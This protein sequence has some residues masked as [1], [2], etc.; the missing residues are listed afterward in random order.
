MHLSTENKTTV[1]SRVYCGVVSRVGFTVGSTV[2]SAVDSAPV[3]S[4]V[5]MWSSSLVVS[6]WGSSVRLL[7]AWGP[8][9]ETILWGS[10]CASSLLLGR[11]LLWVFVRNS[12]LPQCQ[13]YQCLIAPTP[14]IPVCC[15]VPECSTGLRVSLGKMWSCGLHRRLECG[16]HDTLCINI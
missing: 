10:K 7:F 6:L 16:F 9:C 13:V 12:N 11:A 1:R 3:P 4:A 15:S 2:E 8:Q 5:P 14:S